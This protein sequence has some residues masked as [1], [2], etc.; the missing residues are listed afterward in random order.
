MRAK[1]LPPIVTKMLECDKRIEKGEMYL[2]YTL[3]PQD[4]PKTLPKL[5]PDIGLL[6]QNDTIL[7]YHEPDWEIWGW[8]IPYTYSE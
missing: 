3:S 2:I 7:M 6:L 8:K 1:E 5:P 4:H